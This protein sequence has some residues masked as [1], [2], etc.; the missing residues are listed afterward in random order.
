MAFTMDN[1]GAGSSIS[2]FSDLTFYIYHLADVTTKLKFSVSGTAGTSNTV[3]TSNT[4]NRTQT[5][6]DATGIFL[7]DTTDFPEVTGS[8]AAPQNITAVGG[9]AFVGTVKSSI[10]F[11]QG[12]GGAV[13]I[14]ANPQIAAGTVVGQTLKL[15][16]RS[17]ANTLTIKDGTGLSLNGLCLLAADSVI[18]LHWDGTNWV[19]DSRNNL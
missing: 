6:P 2:A 8:R 4:V 17:N 11:V 5:I 1:S 19:E 10:W 15:Q 7:L 12:S 18:D 3:T 16:G 13:T 14:S 9:I